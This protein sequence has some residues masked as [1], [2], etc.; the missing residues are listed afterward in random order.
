MRIKINNDTVL[1]PVG[2]S[3]GPAHLLR[4]VLEPAK[5]QLNDPRLEVEGFKGLST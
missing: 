1:I 4:E 2:V 3:G 5:M